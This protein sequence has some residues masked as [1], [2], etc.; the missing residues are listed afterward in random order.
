[1]SFKKDVAS[2]LTLSR[3]GK[4]RV[5]I[6]EMTLWERGRQQH[7]KDNTGDRVVPFTDKINR[8]LAFFKIVFENHGVIIIPS[9]DSI[10]DQ[11]ALHIQD[12]NLYFRQDNANDQRDAYILATAE[13]KLEKSALILC[14]DKNLAQ[15]FEK[16]GFTNV[17]SDFKNFL[18]ELMGEKAD[19]PKLEIPS[20]D[21]LDE[22]QISTTFTESF[23]SFINKADHRFYEYQKT[24]PTIT[25]KLRA[26]LA[27]MQILDAEIR[28]RVL[29]YAQ[30]FSPVGKR[31]LHLLLEP[32]RYSKEQIESNAQR[33][34]QE[35][36]LIETE[37]HWLTNTQN[38]EAKEICEQA[39]AVVMPEILEIMELN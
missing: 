13:L 17:R 15:T 11:A 2:I 6:S 5:Y 21:T 30:W 7:E 26:K 22:Y 37:N 10:L 19:I 33:L 24:L 34:K 9:D 39:M 35:G 1:M 32:R 29:G 25:D 16:I 28:K 38:A 4:I 12:T 36:L 14:H 8:Y 23:R 3:E 20:L 18:L 27:N 31:D